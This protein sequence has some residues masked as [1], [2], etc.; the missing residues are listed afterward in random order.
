MAVSNDVVASKR[1]SDDA[2][3]QSY[4][5]SLTR[6]VKNER[7]RTRAFITANGGLHGKQS[8]ARLLQASHRLPPRKRLRDSEDE[9]ETAAVKDKEVSNDESIMTRVV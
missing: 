8:V 7:R 9:E 2:N 1:L 6:T 5:T 3:A 4:L